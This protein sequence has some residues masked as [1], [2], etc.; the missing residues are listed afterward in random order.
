MKIEDIIESLNTHI[1]NKRRELNINA[2]GH[3]VLHKVIEP[4]P[5]FK[6]Y[7]KYSYNI[8]CISS[9]KNKILEFNYMSRV[10]SG[11]EDN[12][13]NMLDMKLATLLFD[14]IGSDSYKKVVNGE[15]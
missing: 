5:T 9:T 12:L 13:R 10:I 4:H 6:A 15:I 14:W 1:D 8:W 3:L 2:T 11:L 7:K